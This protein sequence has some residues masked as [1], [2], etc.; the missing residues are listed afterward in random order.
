[1][2]HA[3]ECEPAAAS[4]TLT[5][6][7]LLRLDAPTCIGA[8]RGPF[9]S[10]RGLR[11]SPHCR[12]SRLAVL[13]LIS[14]LG[15]CSDEPTL[16]GP[17]PEQNVKVI[18]DRP[19]S[20]SCVNPQQL[21]V[22]AG[23]VNNQP[24][25]EV[26]IDV[27][28]DGR[29]AAAAKDLRYAPPD[30]AT[31]NR[32]V[33]NGLY[34]SQDGGSSWSNRLFEDRGPNTGLDALTDGDYGRPAG[35]SVRLDHQTDPVV[36]F[37]RD[38]NLY[39]CALAY[40]PN[41][42][43]EPS[44][45]V[46]SRRDRDFNL[47]PG[48]THFIGVENDL[49]LFNDKNWLVVDRDSPADSTIVIAT[50]RFFADEAA[51][52]G[53]AIAVSAD[54]AASFGRPIH[55]PVPESESQLSQFFQPLIGQDPETGRKTLFIFYSRVIGDLDL[56]LIKAPIDRLGPGTAALHAHLSSANNWTHLSRGI[57]GLQP[58]GGNGLTDSF[59]FT[60]FF[61][62]AIDRQSGTLF[63][64]APAFLQPGRGSRVLAYRSN[65]GGRSWSGPVAVDDPQAGHQ[66]MAAAAADSGVLSVLWYDSRGDQQFTLDGPI[67]GIDVYYG[68]LDLSLAVRRVLR[69]TPET[70]RA[71]RPAFSTQ[72]GL[73]ASAPKA[74]RRVSA[75]A[76]HESVAPE[77]ARPLAGRACRPYG[78]IGDYIGLA[79]DRDHAY[80]AWCDL[81]D[82]QG[83]GD[84]CL[85]GSCGGRRNQNIY[86][87]KIPKN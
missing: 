61:Y 37:D 14:A 30:D 47:V 69:L 51:L 78:F 4:R 60:S 50:W 19:G 42:P 34:L 66:V 70:Q 63:V 36:A 35:Q 48:T 32:R 56:G 3:D 11:V 27:A 52:D 25:A 21:P 1:M 12:V 58:H 7:G 18:D 26:A 33:W 28:P 16:D 57:R 54:G 75:M 85:G 20:A 82:V 2:R 17:E 23:D 31:Y 6:A 86:F 39:T 5:P 45:I 29:I 10:R 68:E 87:A 55:L 13:A 80:A 49:D 41:G 24:Q 71:D 46:V 40:G 59:R 43:G 8:G 22:P 83:D 53:G 74:G 76:P 84:L 79:A 15:G 81:R 44:A 73:A 9:S 77:P 62:P 72:V 67:H 38:G 64:A 65:D